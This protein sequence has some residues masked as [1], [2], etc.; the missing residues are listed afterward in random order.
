MAL[1]EKYGIVQIRGQDKTL[2]NKAIETHKTGHDITG[3]AAL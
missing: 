2:R 1:S 3:H